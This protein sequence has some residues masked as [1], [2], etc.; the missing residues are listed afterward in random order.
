[1]TKPRAIIIGGSV[2]GLFAANLLR[3]TGWDAVVFER[4]TEEL[5]GRG[6]G[7]STHPQLH[8]VM[9]RLGIPF[10]DSMGIS[11]DKVVFIDNKGV[12]YD[13]RDTV[14]VMSSWGRIYRSLRDKLPDGSYRLSMNLVNVE[15]DADGVT[16]IFANGQRERGDLLI[17]ADGGR[18]TV[19]EKMQPGVLPSYAG[20]VAWRA[21][22]DEKD[23]PP[24]IHAEIFDRYTYCLP[25]GELFLAYPVPGRNNETQPGHRAYNIVW[26]RPTE[27]RRLADLCTDATGR[28]HGTAIPP[29]MIRPD[30]VADMKATARALVAP[31]VAEIFERDPRP[32]FQAIFDLD[33]P[34]IAFGRVALLG[35]AAFIARPHPGA[36]TTKAAMDAAHLADSIQELGLEKGLAKYQREQGAFGSG[37]VKQGQRDGAYLSEQLLPLEQRKNKALTWPVDDLMNDH[38]GRSEALRKVLEA[39][40]AVAE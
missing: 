34:K 39:S 17:G 13:T 8:E 40:R 22:L 31:Q 38:N 3:S 30:V 32:F 37:I 20:Y 16:A 5:A 2:G 24:H 28:N 1:M 26:Y 19:R 29:P 23:V 9:K 6:A 18:S 35:D 11:V 21:M 25:P 36:G 10:D 27:P 12:T 4:N 14:R 7:I 15:Q 33:S